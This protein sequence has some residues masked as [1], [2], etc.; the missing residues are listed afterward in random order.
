MTGEH[1]FDPLPLDDAVALFDGAPFRWWICGGIALDLHLGTSWRA[2]GDLDVGI[3][4]DDARALFQWLA[5]WDL[6]I[7]A[8]GRLAPWDGRPLDT[9]S[10]ENNVW[11]R[12]SPAEPWVIDVTVGSGTPDAWIYRRDPAI[13]RPWDDAVLRSPD[14][15]PYLAPEIQLL[16]KSKNH[17]PKDE[18]D[19]ARVIPHLDPDRIGF[20]DRHLPPGHAWRSRPGAPPG[21]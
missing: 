17:R 5:G 12:P 6:H 1:R 10:N 13:T 14:G 16:F 21:G 9:A 8:G 7:A 3:A 19:A 2:H 11:V 4:R 15:V 20:L 18:V